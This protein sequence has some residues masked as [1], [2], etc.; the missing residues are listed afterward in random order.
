MILNCFLV[1]LGWVAVWVVELGGLLDDGVGSELCFGRS[2]TA[3][4]WRFACFWN[5]FGVRN[6]FCGKVVHVDGVLCG[7][8]Q[9]EF[10]IRGWS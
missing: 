1:P 7:C 5:G 2:L 10:V 8:R 9:C 3:N 4:Y 6:K